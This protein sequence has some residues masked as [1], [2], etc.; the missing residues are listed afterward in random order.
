MVID[1]QLRIHCM[2]PSAEMMFHIS[3]NR[4]CKKRI[5]ELII[6][7]HEF[8]DRLER[9]LASKHP[10]S[11]FDVVLR[12]HTGDR[13]EL[14]YT[15]SPVD[16]LPDQACLLIEFTAKGRQHRIAQEQSLLQ[17]HDASKNLIRGL[18]HEI[19]NPLGGLRGAAQLL[20]RELSDD[21]KEFT[22]I[23]I[24][25][26]DRLQT[27]VDRMLGPRSLPDKKPVNIHKILEHVRQLVT[28]E[29]SNIHFSVDYD[30]SLPDINADESML[31]QAVLNITRNAVAAIKHDEG[32]IRFKT[33][34]VRKQAIGNETYP[35]V[36][37]IDI[38]DN[39]EGI[40][41]E[42]RENIF[43]P[44]ITGRADG[45]GLG[46]SIAQSLINEHNGLVECSSKTNATTFTI[47]IP[48]ENKH[49]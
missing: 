28:V 25:E 40:P 39:G 34:T 30:P 24:K 22:H 41:D 11:V 3:N 16:Y 2:N 18:A 23:I 49:D 44:M 9:S 42:I 12:S 13:I 14:D 46:L 35:L 32:Q 33:R 48:L 21:N 38:T 4:A 20:E 47:L 43:L 19:K 36:A 26:A 37:R 15:V 45:T 6:D 27:L 29:S 5:D 10:Y 1:Q 8:I 17:Q 31:I 7:E